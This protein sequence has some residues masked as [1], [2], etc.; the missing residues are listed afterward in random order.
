MR[1]N[2]S[3]VGE[4][5][6]VTQPRMQLVARD[7]LAM[8]LTSEYT[9]SMDE[10]VCA[11]CNGTGVLG[12]PDF[13]GDSFG[14][15]TLVREAPVT[16]SA[17]DCPLGAKALEVYE[18][19]SGRDWLPGQSGNPAGH[20]VARRL[21]AAVLESKFDAVLQEIQAIEIAGQATQG[22]NYELCLRALVGIALSSR[23]GKTQMRAIEYI[24]DRKLGKVPQ[25]VKIDARVVEF[26]PLE[27]MSI[28]DRKELLKIA[29]GA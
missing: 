5:G 7:A 29:L 1:V 2:W 22:T 6:D 12:M 15:V 20:S 23:D 14:T 21:D 19:K 26:D 25:A 24:I 10:P 27:G 9:S 17:C 4:Y 28:E 3:Q 13:I 11:R 16:L 8:G 18:P